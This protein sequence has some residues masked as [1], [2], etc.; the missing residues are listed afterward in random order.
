MARI[1]V[2]RNA[3]AG[4]GGPDDALESALREGQVD[5]DLRQVPPQELASHAKAL[6]A[7][8]APLV[9]VSGG[10]GTVS[11]IA[12]ALVG[13]ATRLVVFP[14]GTLNHFA[15]ALGIRTHQDALRALAAGR[16][17][18]VDVGEVNGHVFINGASIG[19]YPQQLR[20]RRSWQPRLGKWP[21]AAVAGIAT[22][23][24]FPRRRV[25]LEGQGMRRTRITPLVWI[26]PGPGSFRDPVANPRALR[27]GQLEV[28]VI[29]AGSRMRLLVL[30][31][32]AAL[33]GRDALR[34]AQ[35]ATD[36]DVHLGESFT[37]STHRA[38]RIDVGVDGELVRLA[39]PLHFRVIPAAVQVCVAPP[40]EERA[41]EEAAE[42][43]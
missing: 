6:A 38:R 7:E 4:G 10:D 3:A 36:C 43:S 40:A 1:P 34:I 5:A 35:E 2:I 11:T 20:M 30:G 9:A 31:L 27:C 41:E 29:G 16:F 17:E 19:L 25:M 37:M 32:K 8:G 28:V 15:A 26:G 18:P 21:A 39:S 12:G 14:G 22:I 33:N 24:G 13:T 23:A 42:A